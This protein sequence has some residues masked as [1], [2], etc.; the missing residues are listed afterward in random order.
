VPTLLEQIQRDAIDP[1]VRV[2]DLL[3][4]VKL[5]A[6]KLGLGT[7]EDWVDHEL[8]GYEAKVPGYR[9]VPVRLM[10]LNPSHGWIPMVDDLIE[11]VSTQDIRQSAALIEDL[12]S[13]DTTG[14]LRSPLPA[15]AVAKLDKMSSYPFGRY[16]W[17]I[18][19]S[20]ATSI[21]DAV[22]NAVLDWAIRLEKAG[23]TG[24]EFSF[25]N[26]DKAKAQHTVMNN[27]NVGSIGSLTGNLGSGNTTGDI[28]VGSVEVRQVS[29][30]IA[31]VRRYTPDLVAAGVSEEALSSKV[32]QLEA[33][34]GRG[35]LNQSV[36]RGLL[37]DIRN[38]V[39]SAGGNLVS[40]GVLSL[41]S[42]MLGTGVP[43]V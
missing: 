3:R 42:Q 17:H 21:L 25:T 2:S 1:N 24:S 12:I 43:A 41:I 11:R 20:Q 9:K 10:A 19:L 18:D 30:L 14:Y 37:T 22:R 34:C 13:R 27:F 7:V 5:A 26:E 38:M 15:A 8:N 32:G 29:D 33:E 35:K 23:V 36:I 28:T 31:Q 4:R 6:A 16:E 40:T 39:S